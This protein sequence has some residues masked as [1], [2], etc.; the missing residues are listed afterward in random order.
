MTTLDVRVLSPQQAQMM[1]WHEREQLGPWFASL[2]ERVRRV[3]ERLRPWEAKRRTLP[4]DASPVLDEV[5]DE[6]KLAHTALMTLKRQ[7]Y[8]E[9]G[10]HLHTIM[11]SHR[12]G[13]MLRML[14]PPLMRLTGADRYIPSYASHEKETL[15]ALRSEIR[16]VRVTRIE[17]LR[18]TLDVVSALRRRAF[19]LGP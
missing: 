11:P 12:T 8:T 3:A 1:Y 16:D 18:R 6:W 9:D 15:E 2:E 17:E 7:F 10:A 19:F 4:P 5:R 14:V 13:L